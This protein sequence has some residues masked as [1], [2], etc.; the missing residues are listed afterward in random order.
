M[1]TKHDWY[2]QRQKTEAPENSGEKKHTYVANKCQN[3]KRCPNGFFHCLA[4][5]RVDCLNS[6]IISLPG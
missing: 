2:G 5:V 3:K 1:K 6:S 4:E